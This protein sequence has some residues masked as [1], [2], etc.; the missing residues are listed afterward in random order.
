[1]VSGSGTSLSTEEPGENVRVH[2]PVGINFKMKD[3]MFLT[4]FFQSLVTSQNFIQPCIHFI[5]CPSTIASNLNQHF[6][7]SSVYASS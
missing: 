5:G 7:I 4:N 2:R 6:F 3:L 1:M